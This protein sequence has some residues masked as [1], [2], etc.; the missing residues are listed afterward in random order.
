MPFKMMQ[1]VSHF[2]KAAEKY[3]VKGLFLAQDLVRKENYRVVIETIH[4]LAEIVKPFLLFEISCFIKFFSLLGI[5]Q[6]F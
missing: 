6:R 4:E 3:G 1:N 5:S 2:L